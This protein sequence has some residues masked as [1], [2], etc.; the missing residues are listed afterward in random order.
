MMKF[1]FDSDE[2]RLEREDF[3]KELNLE[4]YLAGIQIPF[5][6]A[7]EALMDYAERIFNSE[8]YGT[9]EMFERTAAIVDGNQMQVEDLIVKH[10]KLTVYVSNLILQNRKLTNYVLK[11]TRTQKVWTYTKETFKLW[12]VVKKESKSLEQILTESFKETVQEVSGENTQSD[13]R[14]AP[15]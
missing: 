11:P 8:E 7:R 10:N 3:G 2:E 6:D 5:L 14:A 9:P 15:E 13:K 4:L 1:N 12:F